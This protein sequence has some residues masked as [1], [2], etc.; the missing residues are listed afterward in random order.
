MVSETGPGLPHYLLSMVD[1]GTPYHI[2]NKECSTPM[3]VC[4]GSAG[5][6]GEGLPEAGDAGHQ[7]GTGASGVHHCVA[8]VFPRQ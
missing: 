7:H 6:G 2:R 3:R 1:T 4:R 8:H 5:D